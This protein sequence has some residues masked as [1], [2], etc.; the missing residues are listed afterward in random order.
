MDLNPPRPALYLVSILDSSFNNQ[1]G[2]GWSVS[3]GRCL[4][5]ELGRLSEMDLWTAL[6]RAMDE[7][8]WERGRERA[9]D[10]EEMIRGGGIAN[11][12]GAGSGKGLEAT[13]GSK[14]R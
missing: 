2:S 11:A 14:S 3:R 6:E 10:D 1:I 13:R 12:S 5:F 4:V 7:R 9:W 8:E